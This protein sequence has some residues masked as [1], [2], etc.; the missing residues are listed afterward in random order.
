M[1]RWIPY[2][3][4]IRK[5]TKSEERKHEKMSK[6]LKL[7]DAREVRLKSEHPNSV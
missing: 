2:Q 5:R 7:V 1:G 3:R 6:R 4:S